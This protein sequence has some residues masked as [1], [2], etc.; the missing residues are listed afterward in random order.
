MALFAPFQQHTA[1][2]HWCRLGALHVA[3]LILRDEARGKVQGHGAGM[4]RKKHQLHLVSEIRSK[5]LYQNARSLLGE[6]S[7]V[8]DF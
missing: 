2:S 5:V 8:T 6:M 4:K 1:P 7:F 3:L